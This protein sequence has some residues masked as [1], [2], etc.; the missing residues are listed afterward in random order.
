MEQPL[1]PYG[2]CLLGSINLTSFVR[3]PF[4]KEAWFDFAAYKKTVRVFSRMLDNVVELNGLRLPQQAHEIKHKRRHGMG[5]LGLGSACT[6]LCIDYGSKAAE[7][8]AHD[9]AKTLADES[10]LEG[11]ELAKE[12]GMAPVLA[13]KY[14][15]DQL[16]V[17]EPRK[18]ALIARLA[19]ITDRSDFWY[20][21]EIMAYGSEYLKNLSPEVIQGIAKHGCRYSHATSIAPTGTISLSLN[22]NASNGIEPS[23]SHSYSRNKVTAGK[24]AKEKLTVYSYELLA[25]R[26][27]VNPNAEPFAE[28]P[29]NQLPA[30][31]LDTSTLHPKAHVAMQA[32]VQPFIDSAISKTTNVPTDFDFGEFQ[33]IYF[34]A[35]D[36]GLKG[37]TTFRFNPEAFQGVLVTDKDLKATTYTFTLEDGST[38]SARG[39]EDVT[40]EGETHSA[41]NLFD[42]LKEGYYGKF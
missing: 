19:K 14:T 29:A 25:Y 16:Q 8:F 15:P 40:Y 41:A 32:A 3:N 12:K 21:Y 5:F 22:N 23:F 17:S 31:F 34:D 6:M 1:P 13:E 9:V 18:S 24:K 20:G 4:T 38:V 10:Y 7:V 37:C 28:D 11:I 30:Y 33:D 26:H 39:D 42:A 35:Y 27:L 36:A 2:S